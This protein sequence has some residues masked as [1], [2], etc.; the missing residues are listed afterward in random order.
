M[1]GSTG[2]WI[3]FGLA[4]SK[5]SIYKGMMKQARKHF[6]PFLSAGLLSGLLLTTAAHAVNKGMIVRTATLKQNPAFHSKILRE[7]PPGTEVR[8]EK[9]NGGWQQVSVLPEANVT[10]WVRGYQVRDD[11]EAGQAPLI[12]NKESGGVLSG[13]SNLSRRTSGLFGRREM[14]NSG[15]LVATI[16]VRGL[17]EEDLN[18]ARPDPEELARLDGYAA[19]V[20]AAKQFAAA[21]GLKSRKI[22]PLPGP[23]E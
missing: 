18:N 11:V 3:M 17:S 12:Q 1:P 14:E 10:G 15:N 16:G 21:G 9:R 8:L 23:E 4:A 6:F 13:L 7:L 20:P 5:V 2:F 19:E 22:K